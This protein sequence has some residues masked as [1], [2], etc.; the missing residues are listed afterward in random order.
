MKR[1]VADSVGSGDFRFDGSLSYADEN[2]DGIGDFRLRPSAEAPASATFVRGAVG[3]G[4]APWTFR[5]A[6][7]PG[8][9]RTG[10]PLCSAGAST[11]EVDGTTGE[12]SIRLAAGDAVV[13]TIVNERDAIGT[14]AVGKV[15]LGGVGSFPVTIDAP[16]TE[17]DVS[18]TLTTTVPG[19]P[20]SVV[21]SGG[22]IGDYVVTETLPGD[23]AAG[24]WENEGAE[25]AGAAVPVETVGAQRIVRVTL[26]AGENLSCLFINRFTPAGAIT[27]TKTTFGST[28]S[29]PLEVRALPDADGTGEVGEVFRLDAVTTSTGTPVAAISDGPAPTSL[30]VGSGTRYEVRELLPPAG[31]DGL[32][33]VSAIDC[34]AALVESDLASG[35]AVVTLTEDAPLASCA[36]T[37]EF[38]P[39]GRL[40]VQLETTDGLPL[41]PAEAGTTASCS[42]GDAVTVLAPAGTDR[43]T[44]PLYAVLADLDCTVG[45]DASG[46]GAGVTATARA[47]VSVDGGEP[48][49]T[50]LGSGT[51]SIGT[52]RSVVVTVIVDYAARVDPPVVTPPR[53]D[54]PAVDAGGVLPATGASAGTIDALALL[55]VA[56]LASLTGGVLL[57]RVGARGRRPLG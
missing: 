3:A 19:E 22:E 54:A 27:V 30:P 24:S 8:F 11:I 18:A 33:R 31:A 48:V 42:S 7:A 4:D 20:V 26:G 43:A 17:S 51:F 5:E 2:D 55:L 56:A 13:C 15:T 10:P 32:W 37:N 40:L 53:T 14:E 21:A 9:S 52:G 38:V 12:V 45:L 1:L 49:P 46:A 35:R 50:A 29:F 41:R 34:G 28:G 47:T 16:G 25:C 6:D 39:S 36:F 57:R 44:S 23:T